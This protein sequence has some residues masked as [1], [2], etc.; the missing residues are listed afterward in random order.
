MCLQYIKLS[1]VVGFVIGWHY[2]IE[3]S[4][5]ATITVNNFYDLNRSGT[6]VS[7]HIDV[8]YIN[9]ITVSIAVLA[10]V[11]WILENTLTKKNKVK[12]VTQLMFSDR[13]DSRKWD[14]R[15]F[16]KNKCTFI[17]YRLCRQMHP[18]LTED[19]SVWSW[20]TQSVDMSLELSGRQS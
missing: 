1:F 16:Q 12:R 7:F 17:F 2:W 18:T 13:E 14:N 10:P 6:I 3:F 11:M 5:S 15:H 9:V 8:Q 19:R 20:A 4:N